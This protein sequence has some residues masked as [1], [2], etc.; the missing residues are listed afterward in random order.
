MAEAAGLSTIGKCTT[1]SAVLWAL[2]LEDMDEG[3]ELDLDA[4]GGSDLFVRGQQQGHSPYQ[5]S[6]WSSSTPSLAGQPMGLQARTMARSEA[7]TPTGARLGV[8]GG[9]SQGVAMPP[10][11]ILKAAIARLKSQC[12]I[13][14]RPDIISALAAFAARYSLALSIP[15]LPPLPP[16]D[17]H[18]VTNSIDAGMNGTTA[19]TTTVTKPSLDIPD[20]LAELYFDATL[21]VLNQLIPALDSSPLPLRQRAI[22]GS[23]LRTLQRFVGPREKG[24]KVLPISEVREAVG[25]LDEGRGEWSTVLQG[26]EGLE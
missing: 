23:A 17:A 3:M 19:P 12:P 4:D 21:G 5:S 7:G 20:E 14:L 1:L 10:P 26:L 18:P 11:G 24:D 8:H 13:R 6:S 16:L 9:G 15:D 2:G 22:Q 25:V